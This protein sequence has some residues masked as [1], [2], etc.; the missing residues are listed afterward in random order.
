MRC[1]EAWFFPSLF[2]C[3]SVFPK[4]TC[5]VS[6]FFFFFITQNTLVSKPASGRWSSLF[7]FILTS[8][9]STEA[10]TGFCFVLFLLWAKP[11]GLCWVAWWHT[12]VR[13]VTPSWESKAG[14]CPPSFASETTWTLQLC[15][16]QVGFAFLCFLVLIL[17]SQLLEKSWDGKIHT[18][19]LVGSYF[20]FSLQV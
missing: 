20:S 4:T 14:I 17:E 13:T 8:R 1:Q 3:S 15:A 2:Q 11:G 6:L 12:G 10:G 18:K 16:S 9:I 7:C 5:W 19:I